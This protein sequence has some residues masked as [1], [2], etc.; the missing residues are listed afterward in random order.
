V[1]HTFSDL[2]PWP[3][4]SYHVWNLIGV[5]LVWQGDVSN[6]NESNLLKPSSIAPMECCETAECVYPFAGW[7]NVHYRD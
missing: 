2:L 4:W 5:C 6:G 1:I 3:Q 7:W